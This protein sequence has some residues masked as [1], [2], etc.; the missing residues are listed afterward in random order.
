MYF[1][2]ALAYIVI[3]AELASGS[4]VAVKITGT[5]KVTEVVEYE[6]DPLLIYFATWAKRQS[7]M[8][9][10]HYRQLVDAG[11]R[12]TELSSVFAKLLGIRSF[13]NLLEKDSQR[14]MLEIRG[15]S[16]NIGEPVALQCRSNEHIDFANNIQ[17]GD[18]V[19]YFFVVVA[20]NLCC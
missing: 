2:A 18:L 5:L 9:D 20:N 1:R 14:K 12:K 17:I 13:C 11:A 7:Q 4:Q 19:S 16:G 15:W 6:Q 3:A 10:W 8:V